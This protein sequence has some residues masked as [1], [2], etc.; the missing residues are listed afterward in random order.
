MHCFEKTGQSSQPR[1]HDIFSCDCVLQWFPS[2]ILPRRFLYSTVNMGQRRGALC[3]LKLPLAYPYPDVKIEVN[4]QNS[5]V[6]L[7]SF[8]AT[9]K[10][11][12]P[13]GGSTNKKDS[14]YHKMDWVSGLKVQR[15]EQRGHLSENNHVGD[16]LSCSPLFA[17]FGD[18]EREKRKKKQSTH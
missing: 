2:R 11:A 16:G 5:F 13:G 15:N 3:S 8:A 17:A 18:A 1:T 10:A 12:H 7:F 4:L 6:F 14:N 9:K